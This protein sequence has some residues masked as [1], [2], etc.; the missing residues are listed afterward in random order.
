MTR[1]FPA[2][3]A[4]WKAL[5]ASLQQQG[6]ARES[7]FAKQ[8]S[9][10]L[11]P[12]D[13]EAHL[14]LGNT[15]Q[16]L[17]RFDEA[18]QSFRRVIELKPDLASAYLNLGC[19]LTDQGK[20]EEALTCYSRAVALQPDFSEAHNNMGNVLKALDRLEEAKACYKHAVALQ[21]ENYEA[22]YNLGNTFR[23]LGALNEAEIYYNHA[24]MLAPDYAEAH[25]NLGI[26]QKDLGRLDEA[27]TS[28]SR[29]IDLKPDN[30]DAHSNLG[31]AFREMGRL[32]ES[33]ASF[34]QA[35]NLN[36][37]YGHAAHMLSAL[38]GSTPKRAP[39]DYVENLFDGY[40]QTFDSSLVDKLGYRVPK[41]IARLLVQDYSNNNLGSVLDLG[42]G[43]GLLGVEIAQACDRI[44]GLDI[45]R[46]MLS[47]AQERGVYDHLIKQDIETFLA[48]ETLSFDY[49]IA[50]DVFIY[51][52]ELA[53]VFRSI[54][55]RNG[56]SG[57]LVFSVEH[58]DG[59]GFSLL[60]S[61]R[62]AHS[63]PYIEELCQEFLYQ[64][65]HFETLNLRSDGGKVLKG[66]LYFLSF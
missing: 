25:M 3:P 14:N 17:G 37:E 16:E 40:A 59:K 52:G 34:R 55:S 2:H 49:F 65:D 51:I 35:L 21:P 10:E 31:Y 19:A 11:S 33:V 46:K 57:R 9:V 15:L 58:L 45:S 44:V 30:P 18:E 26:V 29:A 36:P 20:L 38:T 47:K 12:L 63:K 53:S 42:C 61:G 43:T 6:M 27:I 62:Y 13:H 48:N 56:S 4:A 66:G 60:P 39:L 7:L 28:Y 1:E 5:G 41:D 64:V 22:L 24:L 50:T 32:E 8:R 23:E 54:R